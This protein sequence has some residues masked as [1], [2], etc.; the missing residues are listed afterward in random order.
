MSRSRTGLEPTPSAERRAGDPSICP[1]STRNRDRKIR[2]ENDDAAGR[3]AELL[4]TKGMIPYYEDVPDKE[5]SYVKY[6]IYGAPK[7]NEL[8][9]KLTNGKVTF[10]ESVKSRLDFPAMADRIFGM[11][12][13][14]HEDA[15]A[16][17]DRMWEE[18]KKSLILDPDR[19]R[20][21]GD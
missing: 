10:V 21:S 7:T 5:V 9:V 12:I 17:T 18:H 3:L 13:L 20:P 14:D 1:M 19:S 15:L 16:L 2:A 8:F 4:R 11:D 6:S